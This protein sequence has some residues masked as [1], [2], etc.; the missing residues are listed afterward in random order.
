MKKILIAGILLIASIIVA[1]VS[2]AA[3]LLYS[4]PSLHLEDKIVTIKPGQGTRSITRMLEAEGVI[5]NGL[6][7]EIYARLAGVDTGLQAGRYIVHPGMPAIEILKKIRSGDAVFDHIRVTVPEGWT[8]A[9]IDRH[10]SA[11]GLW[12]PKTFSDAAFNYKVDTS[13]FPLLADI[14]EG[15]SIEGYLF[16]ETY[17]VLAETSPI[18]LIE[19]MLTELHKQLPTDINQAAL[20]MGKNLHQILT[21]ASIV[22]KESPKGDENMI[23][24]VFWN[25]LN[26]R[27][28]LESDATVNYVLGTKKLQPTFADTEVQHPYNTYRN[29]G[30]PPGPIGNPGLT[31]I[32]ASLNPVEHEF[33]FFLHKPSRETVFSRSYAEHLRAKARYL[34]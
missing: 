33:I 4:S 34:D 32:M 18:E 7:L 13:R 21:L 15:I 10:L 14:P 17:Y 5:H 28:R 8:I 26:Q 1:T 30:L 9:D 19:K 12:L 20:G 11:I 2:L 3:L 31:A 16:P 25:R 23:A 27:I 29:Y 22:Q 6:A 24:G